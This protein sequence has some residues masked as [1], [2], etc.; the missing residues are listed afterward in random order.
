[1]IISVGLRN[2]SAKNQP[3]TTTV[4]KSASSGPR[5]PRSFENKATGLFVAQGVVRHPC[6]SWRLRARCALL[7]PVGCE[8]CVSICPN[9]DIVILYHTYWITGSTVSRELLASEARGGQ[10]RER[11]WRHARDRI[12][13]LSSRSEMGLRD[14]ERERG[15]PRDAQKVLIGCFRGTRC[16]VWVLVGCL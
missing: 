7:C 4:D 9:R 2:N 8:P 16:H 10:L 14:Q 6:V 15:Y 5:S 3:C 12:I 13:N 1:M 11:G